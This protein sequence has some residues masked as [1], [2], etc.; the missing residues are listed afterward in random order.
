VNE[1]PDV[2]LSADLGS[3]PASVT[4]NGT[5][6]GPGGTNCPGT[7][8]FTCA[9]MAG[10]PWENSWRKVRQMGTA[11]AQGRAKGGT[12]RVIPAGGIAY[13]LSGALAVAAAASAL[14]TYLVSDVLRGPAVM[15]G[16]A[17]GTALVVLLVGVPVLA[18]SLVLARRGSAIAVV[19]WLAATGF[20]LY[21]ALMFV[22]A[23]PANRLFLVY[24]A[25]L[26]LAVWSAGTLLW[27]AD[28]QA[29]RRL[30]PARGPARLAAGYLWA[31]AVLN[32]GAW[33]VRILPS[34]AV[35]GEPAYL[36][37]TGMTTNIVFVQDLALWVPLMAVVAAWLWRREPRG[38]LLGGA[39]LVMGA[40]ESVAVAADQWYGHAADPASTVVSAVLT[41]VFAALAVLS[42]AVAWPL[43]RGL[44]P[45]RTPASSPDLPHRDWAAWLMAGLAVLVAAASAFGGIRLIHDGLGM[46]A[47]YLTATPFRSW[48]LPGLALLA[49]VAVPQLA[50]AILI[51]ATHRRALAASYLAGAALVA[52]I[53]VQ[54]LVMQRYFF[55]QPVV[56]ALGIVE[57][58]LAR[59]WQLAGAAGR[60]PWPHRP[61]LHG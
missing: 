7:A 22:F 20:L 58:A 39:S 44:A 56:A 19:T 50:A 26:S 8:R 45:A 25:M 37:G 34:L 32:G 48:E 43:L 11:T 10:S 60:G 35:S 42:L 53:L 27:Q 40:I 54:L 33:L 14:L 17:R 29:L 28:T 13:W 5:I 38:Y 16:S 36:R 41:P 30:I 21:N 59:A 49:G 61:V 52:W 9:S 24:L 1:E 47:G 46:P 6:P 18:C 15:N 4:A 57:L 23:T 55:L 51:A 2:A 12:G 31:L 3:G